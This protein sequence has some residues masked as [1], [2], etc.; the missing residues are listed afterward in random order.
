MDITAIHT[1]R[2]FSYYKVNLITIKVHTLVSTQFAVASPN[3]KDLLNFIPILK[4]PIT[5]LKVYQLLRVDK[6]KLSVTSYSY[7]C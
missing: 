2:S 4:S 5:E 1:H 6:T 7:E 3:T